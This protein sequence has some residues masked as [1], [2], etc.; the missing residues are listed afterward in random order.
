MM[1]RLFIFSGLLGCRVVAAEPLATMLDLPGTGG[2][3]SRIDYAR[4]PVLPI[5]SVLNGDPATPYDSLQYPHVI[6]H[7]GHLLIACSREKTA[8][9]VV[10]VSLD[11]IEKP[12]TNP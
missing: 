10:K 3:V 8:I 12:T 6:E 1:L 5:P 11:D 9:E 4:L 7:D 2:D